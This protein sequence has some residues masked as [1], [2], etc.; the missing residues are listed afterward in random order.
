ME[1]SKIIIFTERNL[2]ELTEL[3][4]PTKI[5]NTEARLYIYKENDRWQQE[6]KLLK[7]FYNNEPENMANK[8]FVLEH[9][10][11]LKKRIQFEELVF[12]EALVS[13][14]QIVVGYVMPWIRENINM[15]LLLQDKNVSLQEKMNY[16]RQIY[17]IL[18]D[19][20]AKQKNENMPFY[21]GDIHES[22]FI[23]N[24]D[25]Q[26]I[27]AID[28]DSGYFLGALAPVSKFLAFNE[29]LL[30][31]PSKY[32]IDIR[33]D[34]HIPNDNTTILSFIYMFLNTISEEKSYKWSYE[35]FYTYLE[36]LYQESVD[37]EFLNVLSSIYSD[38]PTIYFHEKYLE[39]FDVERN[40]VLQRK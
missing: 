39:S 8:V 21:L 35:K 3:Q 9:L 30:N 24:V 4:L 12:P 34:Q 7:V 1:K 15:A 26:K 28:V 31:Y 5:I 17:L 20:K 29:K 36:F 18:K 33:N 13:V 19:L 32:P 25:R 16:L 23:F 40:Y 6:D 11:Q 14:D 37:P 27:Q 2:K 38:E 22:N 10:M